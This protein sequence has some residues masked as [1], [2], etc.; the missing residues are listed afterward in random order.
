MNMLLQNKHSVKKFFFLVGLAGI[1]SPINIVGQPLFCDLSAE[2]AFLINAETGK[3]LFSKNADSVFYPASTTKAAT[4]LYA[5][6]RKRESLDQLVTISQDA[7][8]CVSIP[9]RRSSGKHPSYRLEFGGTHMGLKAGEQVD[10]KTLL[11]GLMLPSANDGANAIA[12]TV[13]GSVLAFVSE[14]NEFLREIGCQNTNFTNPHGLPDP[15]HKTTARDLARIGQVAMKDPIFREIVSSSKFVKAQTNKQPETILD[16][17]NALVKPR[18]KHFYPY[19]TGVKIGYTIQA[20]HA[21]IASAEKGDRSLIAVVSHKEG[22][23]Q[24]YRSVIQLFETAF[25]EPKQTRTLLSKVHDVFHQNI[26]GA[27]SRLTATLAEDLTVSFYP[28]EEK[29]FHSQIFWNVSEPPISVGAKVGEVHIFDEFNALQKT[30]FLVAAKAVEATFSYQMKQKI[31]LGKLCIQKRRIYIAYSM[32]FI[33]FALAML[34][35]KR[36]KKESRKAV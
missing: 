18:H 1:F 20:G 31:Q 13:S 4:A 11:Y 16:Q 28:S 36:A 27:K 10:L 12:E 7:V 5:L 21:M 23:A 29:T 26:V 17:H 14:L 8:A 35:V 33:L 25:A 32:A 15:E 19:A 34:A 9:M 22:A 24:R 2:T 30:S 3:P 6:H